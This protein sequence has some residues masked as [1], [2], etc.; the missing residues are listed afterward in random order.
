MNSIQKETIKLYARQLKVPTFNN[1]E[2]IIRQLSPDDGYEQFLIELMKQEVA[3]RSVTGQKRR[4]KAA[5]FPSLKTLDEFDMTRLENV[6]ENAILEI[7]KAEITVTP[8]PQKVQELVYNEEEQPLVNDSETIVTPDNFKIKYLVTAENADAPA[9]DAEDWSEALPEK[10]D[11]GRYQV[12]YKVDGNNNYNPIAPTSLGIVEIAK[13]KDTILTAPQFSGTEDTSNLY[14]YKDGQD[15]DIVFNDANGAH[16]QIE[17]A[18]KPAGAAETWVPSDTDWSTVKPKLTDSGTYTLLYR[19]NSAGDVNYDPS[20]IYSAMIE[21]QGITTTESINKF[22]AGESEILRLD[23][24][25]N[26][27]VRIT[28]DGGI[29]DLN[30]HSIRGCLLLQ[31][32]SKP[33]IV[34][35]GNLGSGGDGIDD[36]GGYQSRWKGNVI[37]ANVN[38]NIRAW[39]GNRT[40]YHI[41]ISSI[42]YS[43]GAGLIFQV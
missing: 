13:A 30:G 21:V 10:K 26:G 39:S 25:I 22:N 7:T 27:N 6:S 3:E 41:H 15:I 14:Y 9:A 24:D 35:N 34:M 33:I 16:G 17:Y 20:D 36:A 28:R 1:Y 31:N 42:L 2:K 11:A 40:F 23:S 8:L 4:I 5:K 43:G 38:F 12:W 37:I 29:I 18:W 32:N 19:S